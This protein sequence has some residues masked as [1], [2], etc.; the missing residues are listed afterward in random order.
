MHIICS[1]FWSAV[2]RLPLFMFCT[3]LVHCIEKLS[4]S[5]EPYDVWTHFNM[6]MDCLAGV[7]LFMSCHDV[8]P[9]SP[10]PHPGHC[11]AAV[12]RMGQ[13]P[14]PPSVW[15]PLGPQHDR[16]FMHMRVEED[17]TGSVVAEQMQLSGYFNPTAEAGGPP[18]AQQT[19]QSTKPNTTP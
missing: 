7:C 6:F 5:I 1:F 17:E 3:L 13:P 11:Q 14:P 2:C 9:P 12:V 4:S 18:M 19:L 10:N 8:P 16:P 15:P